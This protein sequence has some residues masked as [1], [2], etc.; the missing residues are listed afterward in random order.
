MK[1]THLHFQNWLS[2][3]HLDNLMFDK[4]YLFSLTPG[5]ETVTNQH[6]GQ[7]NQAANFIY[8]AHFMFNN[9][10]YGYTDYYHLKRQ[11]T[12]FLL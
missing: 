5:K 7:F 9:S 12:T 10:K 1:K 2:S 11:Y 4:Q 8:L 3:T 6:K